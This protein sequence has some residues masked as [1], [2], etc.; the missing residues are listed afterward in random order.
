[1]KL[2]VKFATCTGLS[3]PARLPTTTRLLY[4]IW[5]TEPPFIHFLVALL[6]T[7]WR[8]YLKRRTHETY[9]TRLLS[10]R[11][12]APSRK[13]LIVKTFVP[14]TH[15]MAAS[16]RQLSLLSCALVLLCLLQLQSAQEVAEPASAVIASDQQ[17]VQQSGA[18]SGSS[19]LDAGSS[20]ELTT[21]VLV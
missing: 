5:C 21:S 6:A 15:I 16:R 7:R 18:L 19:V 2:V 11:W 12:P 4:S 3:P 13:Y 1:M 17:P 9:S 10:D 14:N 20:G 8:F